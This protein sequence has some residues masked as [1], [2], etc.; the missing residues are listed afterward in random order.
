MKKQFQEYLI[1]SLG[2]LKDIPPASEGRTPEKV[3]E[4][5]QT[6]VLLIEGIRK[7]ID[8]MNRLE[9][10]ILYEKKTRRG[11]YNLAELEPMFAQFGKDAEKAMIRCKAF[12]NKRKEENWK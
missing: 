3:C 11:L 2:F 12:I 5:Y 1:E 8:E 7:S 9:P 6:T 10:N 4:D